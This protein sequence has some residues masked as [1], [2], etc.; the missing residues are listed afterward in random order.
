L[1]DLAFVPV[2]V[3]SGFLSTPQIYGKKS[4]KDFAFLGSRKEKSALQRL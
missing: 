4:Q 1:T 2:T 3:N